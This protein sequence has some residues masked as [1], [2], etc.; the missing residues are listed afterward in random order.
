MIGNL[1][2]AFGPATRDVYESSK[3]ALVPHTTSAELFL[4]AAPSARKREENGPAIIKPMPNDSYL[5]ALLTILHSIPL[6]RNA[7]LTPQISCQ[8][9]WV[10]EDWWKGSASAPARTIDSSSSSETVHELDLIH[11]T[12]RLIA[13]L[14]ISDR[15]YASLGH[16]LQLDAWK[17]SLPLVEDLDDE[18]LK[19][20]INWSSAY[21][22]HTSQ[23]QLNGVL[24]SMV[25]A[26]GQ[27]QESFVLDGSVIHYDPTAELTLY[28]VLDDTLLSNSSGKAHI[29]DISN[30]L[31][32]RLTASKL[33]ATS[34]DCKI[35]ATFYADRYLE[36]NKVIIDDMLLEVKQ[37]KD[38]LKEINDKAQKL[39]YHTP[40]KSPKSERMDTL[41]LLKTSMKAFEPKEGDLIEDPRNSTIISQLQSVYG[42]IE[43]KIKSKWLLL[44]V[45]LLFVRYLTV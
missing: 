19:Y 8:S 36:E 11:E 18:L 45:I 37:Y 41:K 38:Q 15:A 4:D 27:N 24:R 43:R 42:S 23:A 25:N 12:Q 30:V 34:L 28:D 13:F 17:Q 39:K 35:P 26:G 21:Q 33:D 31:I 44:D 2:P 32:L 29:V 1:G 16:L 6:F 20:L 40:T 9:Y 10:G 22:S 7:L 3:W 14:D 5:P